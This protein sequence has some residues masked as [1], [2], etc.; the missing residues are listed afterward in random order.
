M[1]PYV[2]IRLPSPSFIVL[3]LK[4]SDQRVYLWVSCLGFL[5]FCQYF[6]LLS[7]HQLLIF[8]NL[9][10][11]KAQSLMRARMLAS[12]CVIRKLLIV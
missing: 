12:C 8:L 5:L 4:A 9:V 10:K 6:A 7:V 11:C 1:T 3:S 2:V